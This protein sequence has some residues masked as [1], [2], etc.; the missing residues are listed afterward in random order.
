MTE[1][2]VILV[3]GATGNVGRQVVSQLVGTRA[4]LR[5][6]ARDPDSAGLPDGI[7]VVRGDLS[8][9]G[10]LEACL[11]GVDTVF[12]VWPFLTAEAAPAVLEVAAK[13]A[14]R[15]VYLSSM[16]VRDDLEEQADPINQF[17]ADLERL[18]EES[19]LER[20]FLRSH[21]FATNALWWAPQIRADGVVREPYGAAARPVT[22]ERNIAAVAAR[23]LTSDGHGGATYRLTGP[24]VLTQVEQVHIIGE[25][26][27]RALRFDGTGAGHDHGGRDHR[28][29]GAHVP[30]M[31]ARPRRRLPP[32]RR[33]AGPRGHVC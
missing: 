33:V 29:A 8:D 25:A 19:G 30:R 26:I 16:G 3:T 6:L 20:T 32:A 21:T 4:A 7:E 28:N 27:G 17:H 2:S 14:R 23:V 18:I 12:L 11:D 24:Q 10:T 22:H 1:Q 31:G 15:I 9:P 13:H 5:A